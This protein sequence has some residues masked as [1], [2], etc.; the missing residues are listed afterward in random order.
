MPRFVVL[1]HDHPTLHWDFLLE[2]DAAL[3]TWRLLQPPDTS[4]P[5]AAQALSDHRLD[6][7]DYEGPVSRGRGEVRRWDRGEFSTL[8]QNAERVE[9]R[10]HGEKLNGLF[11]LEAVDSA[12]NWTFHSAVE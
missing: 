7:R 4:G 2:E 1:V 6:Y 8:Y 10:L 12:G 9:F 11:V 3:R 5:I